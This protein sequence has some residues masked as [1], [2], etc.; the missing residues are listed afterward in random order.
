VTGNA[1]AF[2]GMQRRLARTNLSDPSPP[3]AWHWFFGSH[4]TAPQRVAFAQDWV[5][6]ER[7]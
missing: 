1:D 4:P 5:K 2:I 7:P 3:A 6:L